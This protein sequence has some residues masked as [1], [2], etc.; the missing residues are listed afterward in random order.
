MWHFELIKSARYLCLLFISTS[1]V[2]SFSGSLNAQWSE[3]GAPVC[4]EIGF[5]VSQ[6]GVADGCGGAFVVWTDYRNGSSNIDVYAQRID[7]NGY[8]MWDPAGVAVSCAPGE[9]SYPCIVRDGAGGVI[10]FWEDKRGSDY[11]IYAQRLD[12]GGNALWVENGIPICT[13]ASNQAGAFAIPDGHGG[14]IVAWKDYRDGIDGVY[15]QRVDSSGAFLWGEDGVAICT[16]A[17]SFERY[18]NV[19]LV[20]DGK[21]GAIVCWTDHR[22]GAFGR[23]YIRRVDANGNVYWQENGVRVSSR[24]TLQDEFSIVPYKHGAIVAWIMGN[25]VRS[26]SYTHLTLPT[27]A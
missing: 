24:E 9:Q 2:I 10:I 12:G 3:K 16:A 1:I 27:K 22:T 20:P 18:G 17:G 25:D 5:Q 19:K 15:A 11:D 21:G 6:E 4:T 7:F 23:V 13:V 26:V 8:I 14:A